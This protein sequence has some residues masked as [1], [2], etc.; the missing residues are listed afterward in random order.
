MPDTQEIIT[1]TVLFAVV[2]LLPAIWLCSIINAQE[3]EKENED[4]HEVRRKETRQ[5]DRISQKKN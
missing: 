1:A 2:I 5:K 3:K 4:S